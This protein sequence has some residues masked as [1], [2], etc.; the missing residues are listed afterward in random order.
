MV[1]SD[2]NSYGGVVG[3]FPYAFRASD[4]R[5]FRSYVA[6]GGVVAVLA[7][8]LFAG[9]V[10]TILAD[11]VQTTGGTMTFSR[12]FVVVVALVI[13][14]PLLAPVLLAARRHRR[15]S[16]R[17]AY[18]RAMA[19]A[20]YGFLLSV[21][22]ALVISAPP[23]TREDPPALLDPVVRFL[24]DLP[25]VAGFLPLVLGAVGI[26]LAHRSYR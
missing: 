19:A 8:F 7:T 17:T 13:I 15:G 6:I 23:G 20:G 14:G 1:G 5:L 22:L 16:G 3:A 18:D 10:V 11:T 12:A 25:Q 4:S 2:E 26:Y 9:S 24:Y 21:Y